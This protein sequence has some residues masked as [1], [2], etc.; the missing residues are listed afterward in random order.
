M[1]STDKSSS[2]LDRAMERLTQEV[3]EG[4]RHGF[5]E[6]T[7]VCAI[8]KGGRRGLTIKA[9]KSHRFSILEEEIG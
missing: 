3:R 8:E 6:L 9:G 5:F 4:L 7:V 2:T 1:V